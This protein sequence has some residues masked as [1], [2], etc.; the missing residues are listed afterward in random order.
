MHSGSRPD[1][2]LCKLEAATSFAQGQCETKLWHTTLSANFWREVGWP[3]ACDNSRRLTVS[4]HTFDSSVK[5]GNYRTIYFHCFP[6]KTVTVE[7]GKIPLHT[8]NMLEVKASRTH[9]VFLMLEILEISLSRIFDSSPSG[10]KP[11]RFDVPSPDTILS[12]IF[13]LHFANT[14]LCHGVAIRGSTGSF[15]IKILLAFLSSSITA[16]WC[17]FRY[18]LRLCTLEKQKMT[19]MFCPACST[20]VFVVLRVLRF[21]RPEISCFSRLSVLSN[22]E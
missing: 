17:L 10:C 4:Y 2:L 20:S 19:V 1:R 5:K 9:S 22:S 11:R 13:P 21:Q 3:P 18:R 15:P 16:V 7:S 8:C 14:N 6:N 12:H